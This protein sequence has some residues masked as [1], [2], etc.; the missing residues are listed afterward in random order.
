MK[1]RLKPSN[2]WAFGIEKAGFGPLFL[3]GARLSA[4]FK[5][6]HVE[7]RCYPG[8]LPLRQCASIRPV[9]RAIH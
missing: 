9:L 3:S 8:T 7:A 4:I 2:S 6:A 5:A 1:K